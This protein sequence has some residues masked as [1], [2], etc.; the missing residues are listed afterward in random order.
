MPDR[1]YF[2]IRARTVSSPRVLE[3]MVHNED[4]V[5]LEYYVRWLYTEAQSTGPYICVFASSTTEYILL[6]LAK[7]KEAGI[8]KYQS[9]HCFWM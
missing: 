4:T 6:I 9:F 5:L 2:L 7:A 1:T 3:W 8:A